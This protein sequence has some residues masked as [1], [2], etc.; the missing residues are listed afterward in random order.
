MLHVSG[1]GRLYL[2]TRN[3]SEYGSYVGSKLPARERNADRDVAAPDFGI[4]KV[5]SETPGETIL[6]ESGAM[7]SRSA[8]MQ[9]KTSMRG[10][11]PQPSVSCS[12]ESRFSEHLYGDCAGHDLSR[13]L[14]RGRYRAAD[15]GTG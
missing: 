7:V 3:P 9:M 14:A 11:P 1:K 10:C 6:C 4:L 15:P 13:R 12:A 5:T 8:E 2:Q